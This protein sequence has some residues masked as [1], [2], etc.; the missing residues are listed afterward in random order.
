MSR[1]QPDRDAFL[2]LGKSLSQKH[3]D[4]LAAQL[5]VVQSVIVNFALDHGDSIKQDSESQSKFTQICQLIGIDPLELLLLMESKLK[6]K[7]NY[8]GGLAIRVVEICQDTR[9]INGGLLSMKE[10]RSRLK[11]NTSVPLEFLEEDIAKALAM[12]SILGEGFEILTIS[13]K[14]WIRHFTALGK[15][16]ISSD[17]QKVYELCEFTGGYVT[18]A[19]LRDNFGWDKIRLK[20]VIDEMI[21]AGFLWTDSQG[22]GEVQYWEPSWISK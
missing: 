1:L 18:Q 16:S 20:T 19:L 13:G 3:T 22:L 10:L 5:S 14:K 11:D 17:Q 8:L 2:K 7:D 9:D 4:E 21:M 6:R 12:I 15:S